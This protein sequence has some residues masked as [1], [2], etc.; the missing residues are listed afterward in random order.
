MGHKNKIHTTVSFLVHV[1]IVRWLMYLG[2]NRG[3]GGRGRNQQKK[4]FKKKCGLY[5]VPSFKCFFVHVCVWF[6]FCRLD[7]FFFFFLWFSH[8]FVPQLFRVRVHCFVIVATFLFFIS[9]IIYFVC[10]HSIARRVT[11]LKKKPTGW[12]EGRQREG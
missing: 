12:V 4:T 6:T 7:I 8:S 2:G 5:F 9:R 10:T 11:K 3:G 1:E